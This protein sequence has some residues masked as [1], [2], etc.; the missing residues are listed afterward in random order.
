MIDKTKIITYPIKAVE[1]GGPYHM[2]IL[3]C[4]KKD[5]GSK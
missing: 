3:N 2:Q 5:I 4:L 1:F